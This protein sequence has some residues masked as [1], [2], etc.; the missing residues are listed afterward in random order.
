MLGATVYLKVKPGR[1]A[2][3]EAVAKEMIDAVR[4]NEPGNEFYSLF[5]TERDQEYVFVERWH[6]Q[7]ALDAHMTAPHVAALSGR[8]M[9]CLDGDPDMT[10]YD[11]IPPDAI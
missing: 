8:F 7:A 1:E 3:F 2:D 11:E 10:V 9:D 4:A 5:R 6:D